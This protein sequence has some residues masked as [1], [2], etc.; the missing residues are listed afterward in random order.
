M[1]AFVWTH[2]RYWFQLILLDRTS[3]A[4]AWSVEVATKLGE[5]WAVDDGEDDG[6][7]RRNQGRE[8]KEERNEERKMVKSN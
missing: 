4:L 2:C 7:R 8:T 5:S 3:C 1:T 6:E